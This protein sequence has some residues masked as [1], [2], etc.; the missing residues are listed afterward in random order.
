MLHPDQIRQILRLL[1]P[2]TRGISRIELNDLDSIEDAEPRHADLLARLRT[3][4]AR[5]V[6]RDYESM[7]P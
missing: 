5:V 7:A 3:M 4:F 2:I 6:V 1:A